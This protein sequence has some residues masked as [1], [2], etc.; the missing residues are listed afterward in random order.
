MSEIIATLNA[1]AKYSGMAK[2]TMH[3]IKIVYNKYNHVYTCFK[4][5]KYFLLSMWVLVGED[6]LISSVVAVHLNIVFHFESIFTG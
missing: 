6:G 4:V 5:Q 3:G 1:M 2:H